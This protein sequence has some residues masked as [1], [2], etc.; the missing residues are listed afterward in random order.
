MPRFVA[1][2]RGVNVGGAN[3]VPMADLRALLAGLG[4]R[5]ISTVLNSGNAVFTADNA[6]AAAHAERIRAALAAGLRVDVPVIVK[7]AREMAAI[8]AGNS[9]AGIA[10][11]PSRLLVAF[12][13]DAGSL[14]DLSVLSQLTDPPEQF[15]LGRHA[16]Y[17]WCPGGILTSRAAKALLGRIGSRATSRNWATVGKILALLSPVGMGNV[18]DKLNLKDQREILILNAPTSF[19]AEVRTLAGV[20]VRTQLPAARPVTFALVFATRKA[21]VDALAGKLAKAAE[22]DAILWFA[23]PKGASRRY[24]CDFNRDTGWDAL[25]RCGFEAVRQIAIDEDWSALRFRRAEFIASL[26]R[27]PQR[28][29]SKEGRKKLTAGSPRT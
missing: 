27:A 3:R 6:S 15:A 28:A 24:T 14:R 26:K 20:T 1:L 29:M 12:T 9:L 11:D 5:E 23:Y 7:S 22:G 8:E 17:L 10:A 13:A 21:E 25:G 16:A 19:G 4:M 18:F 2:L